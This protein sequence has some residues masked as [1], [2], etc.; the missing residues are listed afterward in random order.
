MQVV[1]LSLVARDGESGGARAHQ[2]IVFAGILFPIP[3]IAVH[4]PSTKCILSWEFE[5]YLFAKNENVI[6]LPS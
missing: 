1:E 2:L 4:T 3:N 6:T 5:W